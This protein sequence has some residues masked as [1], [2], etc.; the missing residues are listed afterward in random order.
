MDIQVASNFERAL[1]EASGRD[2]DWMSQAMRG[3]RPD[4]AR[5]TIPP[6]RPGALQ[7]R[8]LA[9]RADDS[10]TIAAIA[11]VYRESGLV[12]DPHTA[13]GVAVAA[14]SSAPS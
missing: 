9:A 1:F 7:E 10:E 3:F 5:S 8:Y 11:R 6:P 12:I 13:V 14:E 4:A 2:A